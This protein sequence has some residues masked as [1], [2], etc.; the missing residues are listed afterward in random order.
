MPDPPVEDELAARRG[1]RP[2]RRPGPKKGRKETSTAGSE[3]GSKAI[4]R[5]SRD[6]KALSLRLSGANLQQVADECGFATPS[7]ARQSIMRSLRTILPDET[8]AEARMRELATLD[9]LQM[10]HMP[11]ALAGDDKA[12]TIVLRCVKM[13]VDILGLA[14]PTEIDMRVREG[15][16]VKVEILELLNR[17]TLEALKPFQDEMVRLSELR[18]GAIDVEPTGTLE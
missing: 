2:P 3:S 17:D 1:G 10:H 7:G 12:A 9:R 15:E 18:A 13:R 6:A 8:R 14:A 16:P 11:K 5:A 4:V